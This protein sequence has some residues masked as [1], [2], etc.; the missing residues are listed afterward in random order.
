LAGYGALWEQ[1]CYLFRRQQVGSS[2]QLSSSV[3]S[4]PNSVFNVLI[5]QLDL[6][7]ANLSRGNV[8]AFKAIGLHLLGTI[9]LN[10]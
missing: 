9:K 1:V 6:R 8:D 2:K 10:V 3:N 4:L 7:K 5:Q